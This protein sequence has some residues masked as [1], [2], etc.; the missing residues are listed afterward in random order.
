MKTPTLQP[1]MRH[2]AVE[3]SFWIG[4]QFPVLS[5]E[6]REALREL[7][8]LVAEEAEQEKTALAAWLN[9]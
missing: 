1:T 8:A 7:V 4:H 6:Q 5:P 9:G 3:G 2:L